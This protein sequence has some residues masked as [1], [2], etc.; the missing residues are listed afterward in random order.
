[1]TSN[2]KR[3]RSQ[4][5]ASSTSVD[6]PAGSNPGSLPNTAST[7]HQNNKRSRRS[8]LT[9]SQSNSEDVKERVSDPETGWIHDGNSKSRLIA[10]AILHRLK[11]E[12]ESFP[13]DTLS[14]ITSAQSPIPPSPILSATTLFEDLP[15]LNLE[16]IEARVK[17]GVLTSLMQF[18][19][20]L[21]QCFKKAERTYSTDLQRLA[22]V[23]MLR[24]LYHELTKG[25]GSAALEDSIPIGSCRKLATVTMG[26]GS[27]LGLPKNDEQTKLRAKE[28]VLLDGIRYKSD[29][30]KTGD[31]VHLTNP[32]NPAR[33]IV[34]QI[35]NTFRRL[36]NG[37]RMVNVCWYYRP[38][39]TV[40]H[41]SRIFLENEVFKT[42]N[43]IDH[44][45]E[46]ILGRCLG[47]FYTKYLRGRPAAPLY[48]RELPIY[49]CEH[50]YKDDDYSFKK[51]KNW[52]SCCPSNVRSE[53][54]EENFQ[55]FP[56]PLPS[57]SMVRVDSPF[58]VP[59]TDIVLGNG[60]PIILPPTELMKTLPKDQIKYHKADLTLEKMQSIMGVLPSNKPRPPQ[61]S[62]TPD[63]SAPQTPRPPLA[64]PTGTTSGSSTP[65]VNTVNLNPTTAT[66]TSHQSTP[67]KPPT[68]SGP[69][70]AAQPSAA[71]ISARP[72]NPLEIPTGQ[73]REILQQLN[74]AR[75][76][77]CL[78]DVYASQ[79]SFEK[80][81]DIIL[82]RCCSKSEASLK[83]SSEKV[84]TEELI[85]VAAPP[86]KPN[87]PSAP[88]SV[89]HSPAYLAYLA[90]QEIAHSSKDIEPKEARAVEISTSTGLELSEAELQI[91]QSD[92]KLRERWN[93]LQI[94][95]P[96]SRL[97]PK[98][99]SF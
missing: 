83:G 75:R 46:D 18:D 9:Q 24:R 10:L 23:Y 35:F 76:T 80:L 21:H 87:L 34:G 72:P 69:L 4:S 41:I 54:H 85:W 65:T 88:S 97:I 7:S 62:R 17:S 79:E 98:S 49:V 8:T 5:S 59:A 56:A 53:G 50:R 84:A 52:E 26:P 39:D 13:N 55:S 93:E 81:P 91:V 73:L 2:T 14:S 61:T 37:Q 89:Q 40:H 15:A 58:L 82:K 27:R 71:P 22:A 45:V 96:L 47:L 70:S 92:P 90:T 48:T 95:L 30:F 32:D 78:L 36:D 6:E 63:S 99:R 64:L 94:L 74:P 16:A 68:S 19:Q 20:E 28:K 43:F 29:F 25:D 33:P 77:P 12:R 38:E 60:E 67:F 1:M 31:W 11:N 66:S 57:T 86:T 42:G 44:V 51:I 3:D